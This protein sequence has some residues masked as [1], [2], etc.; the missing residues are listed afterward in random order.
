VLDPASLQPRPARNDSC[1][2]LTNGRGGMCYM[3]VIP[4]LVTSKY[5]CLLG[6]NLHPRV[7]AD[8]HVFA[9]RLRAWVNIDGFTAPLDDNALVTCRPG[10]PARWRWRI[11]TSA[12]S[13]LELDM[14]VDMLPAQN[15][16]SVRFTHC[17]GRTPPR[18]SLVL[19][20]DCE[21]RSFHAETDL[22]QREALEHFRKH[23]RPSETGRG[24]FFKPSTERWLEVW[25][26]HGHYH[27]GEEI[28]RGIPHPHE[29]TRGQRA[30]GDAWSPG[31]F[32]LP[33]DETPSMSLILNAEPISPRSDESSEV[34]MRRRHDQ[35]IGV[36]RSGTCDWF[37]QGLAIACQA[38]LVRRDDGHSVIAGYPWFL[39]WGRDTL[40]CA[41]GLVIAGMTEEVTRMLQV[42][43]RFEQ[44]GTLPNCIFGDDASNRDT[45]DAPLWYGIVAEE[46][47][48]RDDGAI[49]EQTV[50]AQ[51]RS[52]RQ[53]LTAI[54]QGYLAGTANGIRWDRDSGL[55]WSPSHFTWMDTNHPAGTPRVGY[56][57][58]IQALWIRLLEQLERLGEPA[59]RHGSWGELATRARH[60]LDTLY[61]RPKLGHHSD[62]IHAGPNVSARS[63]IP[64]TALRSNVLLAIALGV[65]QGEHARASVVAARDWLIV[66]GAIRSLAPKPIHPPLRIQDSQGRLLADPERP[67]AGRYEGDEDSRRKPAY[68]N[69]TAWTWPFPSFCE[70]YAHAFEDSPEAVRSARAYL[71]SMAELLDVGCLGHIPEILDGD[72]PHLQRGCLAQAW[73]V[74][75]GLRVWRWLQECGAEGT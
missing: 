8:R 38:F 14:E 47:A 64:D 27:A 56:P 59:P 44:G 62:C 24:F 75:E 67:Y 29:A 10:P 23:T 53:V 46:L 73:S 3:P 28:I 50:N 34:A 71:A 12:G 2:L 57:I 16:V 15:A 17:P 68:H 11:A 43:G 61:W 49:Y 33:L 22:G 5:H 65:I 51:G 48:A 52:I 36:E 19:R 4:H 60:S 70:A 39:D 41:R 18:C 45:S 25:C 63:G 54:A 30:H 7:P 66:P 6:A 9:K 21:D 35:A 26:D 69:G 13:N 20:V 55:I 37:G 74:T 72:A 1:V 32:E 58:E 40:I 42:Y 31:W